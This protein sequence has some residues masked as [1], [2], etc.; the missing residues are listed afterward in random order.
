MEIVS[1]VKH[2]FIDNNVCTYRR[3]YVWRHSAY[4]STSRKPLY[5]E[6]VCHR[7]VLNKWSTVWSANECVQ[8]DWTFIDCSHGQSLLHKHFEKDVFGNQSINLFQKPK[9]G[10]SLTWRCWILVWDV[11]GL[12]SPVPRWGFLGPSRGSALREALSWPVQLPQW[13]PWNHQSRPSRDWSPLLYFFLRNQCFDVKIIDKEKRALS[14][15][16]DQKSLTVKGQKNWILGSESSQHFV[17]HLKDQC[18][19]PVS[20]VDTDGDGEWCNVGWGGASTFRVR[21]YH[22]NKATSNRNVMMRPTP[23]TADNRGHLCRMYLQKQ[24]WSFSEEAVSLA[25]WPRSRHC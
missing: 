12:V 24:K 22:D 5:W 20:G 14:S 19:I 17:P 16:N 21:L 7:I 3:T 9:L 11:V 13:R 10:S 6:E 2:R 15:G 1:V 4:L 18:G 25:N 23:N 8:W